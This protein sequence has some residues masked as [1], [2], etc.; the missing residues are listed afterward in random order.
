MH[1]EAV[2]E[3]ALYA[4]SGM[5]KLYHKLFVLFV[6]TATPRL[7]ATLRI[8]FYSDAY[9]RIIIKMQFHLLYLSLI[10]ILNFNESK[11]KLLGK[12]NKERYIYFNN[13]C[14]IALAD[15]LNSREN[16]INDPDAV[17]L[18][19]KNKRISKR[20]VA[21]SYTHLKIFYQGKY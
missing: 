3:K 20:R 12:G 8:V 18:S 4:Y 11:M 7:S 21:V 1:K 10:H 5:R 6:P 19:R 16:S 14:K 15:Y 13:A 2:Y 9:I 17:F